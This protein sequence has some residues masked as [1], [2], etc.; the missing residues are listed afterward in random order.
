[1][2]LIFK[3]WIIFHELKTVILLFKILYL[4]FLNYREQ[5]SLAFLKTLL[6]EMNISSLGK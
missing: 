3:E 4:A 5:G 2:D 1:M 6:K